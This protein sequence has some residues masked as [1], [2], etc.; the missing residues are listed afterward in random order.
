MIQVHPSI[1]WLELLALGRNCFLTDTA[2]KSASFHVSQTRHGA[3]C[4]LSRLALPSLPSSLPTSAL[5]LLHS[6]TYLH[7]C[8]FIQTVCAALS[9]PKYF[10][11]STLWTWTRTQ[12]FLKLGLI[13]L[14]LNINFRLATK[15]ASWTLGTWKPSGEMLGLRCFALLSSAW[16]RTFL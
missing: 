6:S 11:Y 8:L 3:C 7:I 16:D 10:L 13:N 12:P 14:Y 1:S 9:M 4:F 15:G 2:V 5:I